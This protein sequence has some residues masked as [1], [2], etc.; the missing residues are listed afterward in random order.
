MTEKENDVTSEISMIGNDIKSAGSK[1]ENVSLSSISE[2]ITLKE[3]AFDTDHTLA[4]L[5]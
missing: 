1:R 3:V 4:S 2:T 5:R